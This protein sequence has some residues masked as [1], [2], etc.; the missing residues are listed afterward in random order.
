MTSREIAYDVLSRW[1]PRSPHAARRLDEAF[2]RSELPAG[3][4][5]LAT[6]LVHGIMRRRDTLLALV[7][8]HV[9]RP[10]GQVE[11]GALTLLMLGAY[12]LA[13]LS[14]IPSYA[15]VNE[16]TE[17]AKRVGKP[18]WTGF[19]NAVLRS[20][21]RAVTAEFVDA[22]AANGV[23]LAPGRFRVVQGDPFADPAGEW[24]QYFAAA[25]SLPK[26]LAERWLLRSGQSELMR[27][28]FWYNAPAKLCLRVN[29]LQT[30]RERL[31][32]ALNETKIKARAGVQPESIWLDETAFVQGLPGFEAG[33]FAVQDESAIAAARL[34]DPRPRHDVLDLC[35]APG[36]KTT[37][38][39]ALMHNEG[40]IVA[41][42][43]DA[44][45]LRRVDES[46]RRL[47]VSIVETRAV[48]RDRIDSGNETFDRILVDVPC[49][50]T[51][52]LG[53]RPEVRWRLQPADII[54]LAGIQ[55][56]LLRAA[57]EKLARSGRLVYSTCSIE[58]EENRAVVD[59]VLRERNDIVLL[60]EFHH[61]AGQPAD[62]GYQALLQKNG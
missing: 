32:E 54:E 59:N 13:M 29:T 58:P 12:Q 33:W 34:L 31:L 28:G 4:R 48:P 5:A 36:G 25:F 21:A 3:E 22:P 45:R 14:G 38:L 44:G 9:N 40:R 47:G 35:A 60:N 7:K 27:L 16:T 24:L 61:I 62:G 42:D 57:C 1:Q 52:V 15:V 46:C 49:S 56:R 51:G 2:A 43:V 37:H 19:V 30:T 6:E 17:L 18:Q 8:P 23:P 50:N 10:L 55:I 11:P 20:L 39:A 26:W 41:T 53:K